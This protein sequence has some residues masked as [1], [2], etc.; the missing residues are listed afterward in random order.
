MKKFILFLICLAYVIVFLKMVSFPF[1]PSVD[2]K[3]LEMLAFVFYVLSFVYVISYA[4]I[5]FFTFPERSR[6][7]DDY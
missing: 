4:V 7:E 6:F 1:V 5:S 2:H 3:G